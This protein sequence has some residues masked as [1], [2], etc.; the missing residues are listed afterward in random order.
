[1][2][3][4]RLLTLFMGLQEVEPLPPL[5]PRHDDGGLPLFDLRRLELCPQAGYASFSHDFQ[6]GSEPCGG[7]LARFPL[8]ALAPAED[9]LHEA[10]GF[11]AQ[12]TTTAIERDIDTLVDD[13]GSLFFIGVGLDMLVLRTDQ[14]FVRLQVGLQA[15]FFSG[16][17]D[18]EDGVAGLA[19]ALAGV[20]V[21]DRFWLT[22]DAS[23]GIADAGDWILFNQAGLLVRL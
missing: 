2:T 11:F 13:S 14:A 9:T 12:L 7:L 20:R 4:I 19:G 18:L 16:I 22:W 3:A 15:A 5:M 23:F 6:A 1:M 8:P 10:V 17:D 21:S